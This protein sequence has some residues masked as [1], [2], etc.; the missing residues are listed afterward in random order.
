MNQ[1]HSRATAQRGHSSGPAA[2]QERFAANAR[3]VRLARGWTQEEV[4]WRSRLAVRMYQSIEA[5]RANPTLATMARLCAAFEIDARELMEPAAIPVRRG[6]G[7]PP[8]A[9]AQ[10]TGGSSEKAQV[11]Y[12]RG[13][14]LLVESDDA[15]REALE[16][17]L[18]RQGYHV[19][20]AANAVEALR[21]LSED[22]FHLVLCSDAL[23]DHTASWIVEHAP[24]PRRLEQTMLI[25][26][27]AGAAAEQAGT[28]GR[29]TRP[30]DLDRLLRA[31]KTVINARTGKGDAMT[32]ATEREVS[33]VVELVLYVTKAPASR[34]AARNLESI[35]RR[36]D[37][38]R[39]ALTVY[40][41][42]DD[43]KAGDEADRVIFTPTL[44]KRAPGRR[45][46]LLGDLHDRSAVE[47]MLLDA[48]LERL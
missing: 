27:R 18:E 47:R 11:A 16:L 19:T 31:I 3:R 42:E 1:P 30:L 21:W 36:Y 41:L 46:W 22:H 25:I 17:Y 24:A 40:D 26:G 34:R 37:R 35:L 4:A 33:A 44:I 5:G 8:R 13:D 7:R 29:L 43:P 32:A 15:T 38:S 14:I 10:T 9:T 48:G 45:T 12:P 20:S 23:P 6:P 28:D 39:I 2:L